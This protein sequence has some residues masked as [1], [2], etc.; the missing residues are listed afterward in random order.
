M[1]KEF[2]AFLKVYENDL[3]ISVE[4]VSWSVLPVPDDTLKSSD[5]NNL[6]MGNAVCYSV[7]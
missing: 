4:R 2:D 5:P 7:S 3:T 1:S 6:I